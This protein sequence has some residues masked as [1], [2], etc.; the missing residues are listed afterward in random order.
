MGHPEKLCNIGRDLSHLNTIGRTCEFICRLQRSERA[1]L[2]RRAQK[3]A[4]PEK[5]CNIGREEKNPPLRRWFDCET[6][7][8]A[9]LAS[10]C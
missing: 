2:L 9:G 4:T 10:P 5:L 7:W 6:I 8:E 1:P 3:W